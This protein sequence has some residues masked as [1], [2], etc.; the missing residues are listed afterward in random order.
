[1]NAQSSMF[2]FH[3]SQAHIVPTKFNRKKMFAK[4]IS[5]QRNG[6]KRS[7]RN[8]VSPAD[9]H[10]ERLSANGTPNFSSITANGQGSATTTSRKVSFYEVKEE[11]TKTSTSAPLE[12]ST[13]TVH[14]QN[15][16]E[17]DGDHVYEQK[18]Y[19][20]EA[21]DS[22]VCKTD[23]NV[24]D[25]GSV[26]SYLSAESAYIFPDSPK[27]E[28][29]EH[30]LTVDVDER[31]IAK[32]NDVERPSRITRHK[33]SMSERSDPGFIGP[34]AWKIHRKC[35]NTWHRIEIM[36]SLLS[37]PS[38]ATVKFDSNW[39]DEKEKKINVA[40]TWKYSILFFAQA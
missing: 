38:V 21:Q 34:A 1:M 32:R 17:T 29:L 26:G 37:C 8:C 22:F 35:Y 5:S 12:S 30:I 40:E 3:K 36:H 25:N 27:T 14:V 4:N 33:H 19:D 11:I 9:D 6:R 18:S 2:K 13:K 31:P 39:N 23:G 24:C 7:G 10:E 16:V 20:V 28:T 15:V